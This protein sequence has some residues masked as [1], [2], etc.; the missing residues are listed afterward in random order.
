MRTM[1]VAVAG[2][3]ILLAA[4]CA[5]NRAHDAG[6]PDRVVNTTCPIG[7]HEWDGTNVRSADVRREYRGTNIG[8]CCDHCVDAF[9]D[10]TDAEKERVRQ[11]ALA[12][13][14]MN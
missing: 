8:F 7:K 14:P 2:L 11:A 3:G 6:Q 12:N 9:D 13:R 5:Q 10:M 4:G 1:L